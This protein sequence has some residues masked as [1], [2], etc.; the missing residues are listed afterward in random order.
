MSA[1]LSWIL[2]CAAVPAALAQTAPTVD[3]A[4][5]ND[6]HQIGGTFPAGTQQVFTFYYSDAAGASN[7]DVAQINIS[8]SL[9]G[10]AAC[11][12]DYDSGP[13]GW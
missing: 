6:T 1:R 7:L 3:G 9:G 4:T 5:L 10:A 11:T 8:Q 12:V 2:L 13:S